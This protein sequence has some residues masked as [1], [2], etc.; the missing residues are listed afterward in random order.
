V[1]NV[2]LLF[3]LDCAVAADA[4]SATAHNGNNARTIVDM[5]PP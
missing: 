5:N 4:T 3:D 2:L 1:I